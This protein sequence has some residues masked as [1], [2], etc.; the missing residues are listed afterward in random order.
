MTRTIDVDSTDSNTFPKHSADFDRFLV[1]MAG[2]VGCEQPDQPG[3]SPLS[4]VFTKDSAVATRS[5]RRNS[6]CWPQNVPPQ[7]PCIDSDP[8]CRKSHGR[9]WLSSS[10]DSFV[11]FYSMYLLYIISL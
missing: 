3:I 11:V 7:M 10:L 2:W 1:C 8:A 5:G 6:T 9:F 4:L